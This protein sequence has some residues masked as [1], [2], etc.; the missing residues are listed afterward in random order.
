MSRRTEDIMDLRHTMWR[1]QFHGVATCGPC[2]T[3]CGK[4]ARGSGLC[5]DCATKE[6]ARYVGG[7]KAAKYA[8]LIKAIRELEREDYGYETTES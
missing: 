3:G 5:F 1:N 4:S 7:E 8:E 6:L 2:K